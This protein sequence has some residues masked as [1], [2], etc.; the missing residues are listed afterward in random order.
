LQHSQKSKTTW[1]FLFNPFRSNKTNNDGTPSHPPTG[2]VTTHHVQ[3][4]P[5]H[6]THDN[7]RDK[8]SFDSDDTR[9]SELKHLPSTKNTSSSAPDMVSICN[10][11][12]KNKK[13]KSRKKRSSEH[14]TI[15]ASHTS[16]TRHDP[17]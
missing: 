13:S 17:E 11:V 8:D 1:N 5:H 14:L 4:S 2:L 16:A 3:I 10:T 12:Q 6:S 7:G 9:N 15:T